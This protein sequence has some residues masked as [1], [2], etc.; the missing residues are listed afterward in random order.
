MV[1]LTIVAQA[2]DT[3]E[4]GFDT[5]GKN[6]IGQNTESRRTRSDVEQVKS[7]LG[8]RHKLYRA[9]ITFLMRAPDVSELNKN[10]ATYRYIADCGAPAHET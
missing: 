5:L 6:A 7:L 2:Q 4:A 10:T 3:L 8:M 9:S 1:S